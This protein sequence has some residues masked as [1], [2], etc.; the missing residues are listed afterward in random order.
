MPCRSVWT[1]AEVY[2]HRAADCECRGNP[3]KKIGDGIKEKQ[4]HEVVLQKDWCAEE[5]DHD[6]EQ[7]TLQVVERTGATREHETPKTSTS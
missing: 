3:T 2:G 1:S 4:Q 6:M 7:E 5:H